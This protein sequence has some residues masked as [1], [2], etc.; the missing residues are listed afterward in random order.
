MF[1]L[2]YKQIVINSDTVVVDNAGVI[3]IEG[4]G[5]FKITDSVAGAGFN[6]PA[7]APVAGNGVITGPVGALAGDVFDIQITLKGA[8]R[9]LGEI[10]SG[11]SGGYGDSGQI[12]AFQTMPL[13]ADDTFG[14]ALETSIIE[15]HNDKILSFT[16]AG[17][18]ANYVFTDGYEG[19]NIAKVE[20]AKSAPMT[21]ATAFMDVVVTGGDTGTE[22][23]GNGKQVE[24]EV[25]NATWDNTDSYGVQFGGSTSVDVRGKYTTISWSILPDPADTDPRWEPHANLGYGDAQ[26]VTTYGPTK[27]IAFCNEA[28]AAAAIAIVATLVV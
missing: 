3:E 8:P 25:R 12:L 16:A 20:V 10:F 27:F 9:I 26:T 5:K 28:S 11:G 15:G 24:A 18:D 22:G 2:G 14:E 7:V 17:N 13:T 21:S 19:L 6:E 23:Y 1:D 4:F